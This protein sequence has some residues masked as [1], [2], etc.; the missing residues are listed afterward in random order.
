MYHFDELDNRIIA[1]LRHDGRAPLSKVAQI[2][3]VARATVETRLDKMM[4]SGAVQ[5]FTVRVR[6]DHGSNNVSAIMLI[7]V[8]GKSTSNV[9]KILRSIPEIQKIHTTNGNWDLVV[10]IRSASLQDFD[11]VLNQ[12]RLIDG[13]TNSETNLL[14]S[15]V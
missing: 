13:V 2:L 10:E 6:D 5:G 8:S 1:I 3:S 15:S 12:V 9:I 11:R 4:A 7:H 14:L